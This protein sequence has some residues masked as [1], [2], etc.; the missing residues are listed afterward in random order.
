MAHIYQ[1][2][3]VNIEDVDPLIRAIDDE[4]EGYHVAITFNDR[5]EEDNITE[6][7]LTKDEVQACHDILFNR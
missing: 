3:I 7:L 5:N 1:H 2:R 6:I 4:E